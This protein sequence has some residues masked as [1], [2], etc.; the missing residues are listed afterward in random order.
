MYDGD[1][2]AWHMSEPGFVSIS[3]KVYLESAI[4]GIEEV[5]RKERFDNHRGICLEGMKPI[6]QSAP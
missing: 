4:A 3:W 5:E 1:S 6:A 2:L